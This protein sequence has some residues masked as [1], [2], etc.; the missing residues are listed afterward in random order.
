LEKWVKTEDLETEDRRSEKKRR[1]GIG[2]WGFVEE[3]ENFGRIMG[4]RII[5]ESRVFDFR[6]TESLS[7]EEGGENPP[8]NQCGTPPFSRFWALFQWGCLAG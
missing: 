2:D 6:M 8:P 5:L 7:E 3:T 1:L 4:G